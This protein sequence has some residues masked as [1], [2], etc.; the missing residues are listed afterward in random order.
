MNNGIV[1]IDTEF[2]RTYDYTKSIGS[3]DK[4]RI[5]LSALNYGE[6][7]KSN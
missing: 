4:P 7:L 3:E 1:K 5:G 2:Q 6:F